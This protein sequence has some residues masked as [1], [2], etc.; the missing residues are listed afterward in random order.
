MKTPVLTG[1]SVS[2]GNLL[3]YNVLY[4]TREYDPSVPQRKLLV[5]TGL[6]QLRSGSRYSIAWDS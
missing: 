5:L 6:P 3:P 1:L 4:T 2:F